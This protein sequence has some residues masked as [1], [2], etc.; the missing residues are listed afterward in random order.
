MK[1]TLTD[2]EESDKP[3]EPSPFNTKRKALLR[4]ARAALG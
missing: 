2:A 4:R 1:K 3:T